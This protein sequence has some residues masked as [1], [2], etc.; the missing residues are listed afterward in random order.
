MAIRERVPFAYR[1]AHFW[2]EAPVG[3]KRQGFQR[4]FL[5]YL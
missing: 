1:E 5:Y 3:F 2:G 4:L